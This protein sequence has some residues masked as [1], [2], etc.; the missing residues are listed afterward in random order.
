[1]AATMY[2]TSP[3]IA[4]GA[5]WGLDRLSGRKTSV[6]KFIG[7]AEIALVVALG[8]NQYTDHDHSYSR[9]DSK[10][11]IDDLLENPFI[12]S[13]SSRTYIKANEGN[14]LFLLE[15]VIL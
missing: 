5:T 13:P 11:M 3:A 15:S 1:M 2:I 4:M 8:I 6:P 10:E 12:C 7:S 9:E 14:L